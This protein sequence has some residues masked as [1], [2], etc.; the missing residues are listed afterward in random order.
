MFGDGFGYVPD[1]LRLDVDTLILGQN[2]GE[3]EEQQGRPFVGKTGQLL[4]QKMLPRA[5]L[6]R[7]TVCLANV[8]KCRMLEPAAKNGPRRVGEDRYKATNK[9]PKGKVLNQA[10]A[11]CMSRHFVVPDEVQYI[12]AQGAIAARGLGL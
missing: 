7:D 11:H 1:E 9:L 10:I 5:G 2:P 3:E 8:L 4:A 12:L 6:T